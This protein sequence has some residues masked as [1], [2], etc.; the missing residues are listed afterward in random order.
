MTTTRSVALLVVLAVV[1]LT[2]APL[3]SGTVVSPLTGAQTGQSDQSDAETTNASVG[4]LMQAN[5]ADTKNTVE[6]GMFEAAYE[7]ADNESREEIVSDRATRLAEQVS[8]LEAERDELRAQRGALSRG[9][10]QSRM[11]TLTVEIASLERSIERAERRA[12]EVGVGE[13]R[14]A[15]LRGNA[16]TMRQNASAEA[17][18][19]TA[20][21]ARGLAE[22]DTP[23]GHG[24]GPPDDR[25]PP[26]EPGPGNGSDDGSGGP[27]DKGTPER[28]AGG[29]PDDPGQP[30]E[31][32]NGGSAAGAGTETGGADA[33]GS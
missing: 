23:P 24:A 4:T 12:A 9:A 14:L 25:G 5:A 29:A 6:S 7:S 13:D 33:T 8:R 3:A 20:A 27:A 1:G 16:A 19:G 28:S 18:P 30:A 31:K 10:Y 22:A 26:T 15:A 21:V 32:P 11:A 17:G 2:V